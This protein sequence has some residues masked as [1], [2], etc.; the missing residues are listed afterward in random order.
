MKKDVA[1]D[2]LRKYKENNVDKYGI[3]SMGIFG[4]VARDESSHS[5]DIDICIQTKVPNMFNIIHIKDELQTL[6]SAHVD[7]I[8]MREN[9]NPFL[10]KRIEKDAVYV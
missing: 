4:S 6:F 9:M 5:S 10:K 8:R 1:V 7:I 2:I 3:L